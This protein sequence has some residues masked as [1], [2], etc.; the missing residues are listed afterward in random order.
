M[1]V[2]I[3]HDTHSH[4]LNTSACLYCSTSGWA[5]GPVFDSDDE[6]DGAERASAFLRWLGGREPR[7]LTDS[8]LLALHG[9][10][11]A[12]EAAQWLKEGEEMYPKEEEG[13][14]A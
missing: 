13:E 14:M 4:S 11:R 5:F 12:Q 8:E 2:R 6:H 7:L 9:E 10:W 1:G 3:L